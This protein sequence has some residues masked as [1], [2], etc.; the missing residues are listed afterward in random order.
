MF[1]Y[2]RGPRLPVPLH[3]RPRCAC[4][5]K[6]LYICDHRGAEGGLEPGLQGWL[7]KEAHGQASAD[8]WAAATE[9]Q[10]QAWSQACRDGWTPAGCEEGCARYITGAPCERNDLCV[11]S[12]EH[13]LSR[14]GKAYGQR[15]GMQ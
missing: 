10:R 12:R 8:W 4:C 14:A 3:L 9:E 1:G 11:I 7:A 2:N 15:T 13:A 5:V 6:A